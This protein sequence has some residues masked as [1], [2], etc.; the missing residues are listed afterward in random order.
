LGALESFVLMADVR[1]ALSGLIAMSFQLRSSIG[2][3]PK[4]DL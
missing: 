1:A 3:S 4:P 2:A